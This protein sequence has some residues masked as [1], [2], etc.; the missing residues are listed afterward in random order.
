MPRFA[1]TGGPEG[2][3]KLWFTAS[4]Q[5]EGAT[6][7]AEQASYGTAAFADK[8]RSL[9]SIEADGKASTWPVTVSDWER[10]A[11]IV[12]GR[13]LTREEW[14]RFVSGYSYQRACP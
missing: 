9:I 2:G 8:G 11:C 6:L 5:Q 14:S 3:L 4:L 7:N 1:T 10:H 12:A 13:S